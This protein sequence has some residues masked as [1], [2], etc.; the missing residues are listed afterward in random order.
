MSWGTGEWGKTAWG[1]GVAAP[2]PTLISAS[3]GLVARR[4]GDVITVLGTGFQK[5]ILI[6]VMQ[7]LQV[8][9]TC[10]AFEADVLNDPFAGEGDIGLFSLT[11]T[12]VFAH[13]PALED[14]V[15][16]LRVTTDGGPSTILVG[17]LTYEL[18]AEEAKTLKVRQKLSKAWKKARNLLS[19]GEKL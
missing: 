11:S 3:P 4:G 13:T 12:R 9:A 17:A 10:Y 2:V 14:G 8:V 18:F 19:T 16:D 6:E 5:P 15:Y 1:T 7:D